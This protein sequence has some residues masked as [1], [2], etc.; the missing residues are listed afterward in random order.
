MAYTA[1]QPPETKQ[2][3]D[4]VI[5][6]AETREDSEV[7]NDMAKYPA[8]KPKMHILNVSL[9]PNLSLIQPPVGRAIKL[10]K[11]KLPPN[12]PA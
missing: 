3:Q 2:E 12:K 10:I 7:I 9:R 1:P 4:I 6:T 8:D 5:I 11:A